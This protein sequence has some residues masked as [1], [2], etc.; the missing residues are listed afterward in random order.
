MTV[1]NHHAAHPAQPGSRRFASL[2]GYR[3]V[4][5]LAVVV[6]HVGFQTAH[7]VNGPLGSLVARLDIGVAL[8]FLLSGFL[9]YLP[10]ARAATMGARRPATGA[11]LWRRALRVMPAYWLAV[12]AALLLV[13]GN[14]QARVD[15]SAWLRQLTLTQ[16]YTEDGLAPGLTQMWSL[17]VEVSFYLALPL[18]AALSTARHRGDPRRSAQGQVL[19]LIGFGALAWAWQLWV[20]SGGGPE[21]QLSTLWLPAYLDWFAL[22]MGFAVLHTY[23]HSVAPTSWARVARLA[24]DAAQTPWAC[25]AIAAGLYLVVSTPLAGPLS[26]DTP[27]PSEALARHILYGLIASLLLLPG[28][29]EVPGGPTRL[30]ASPPLRWLGTISYGIFLYHLVVLDLVFAAQNRPYFIGGFWAVLVPT[31][32]VTV[33]VSAISW[34]ALEKRV[35]RLKSRGPGRPRPSHALET[36]GAARRTHMRVQQP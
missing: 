33:G 13:R 1:A 11:Y 26:L 8:F 4:A 21:A 15:P 20:R 19:V 16:V 28:F 27:T 25:W 6:T 18:L 7:T 12:T 23:L 5:A 35:L 31:V 22:G 9:L 14:E 10:H 29:L 24:A 36:P 17:C 34:Y 3:A 2:D 30:L 32:T